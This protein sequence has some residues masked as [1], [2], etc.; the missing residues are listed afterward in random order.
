MPECPFF[1]YLA[2]RSYYPSS[3]PH[4]ETKLTLGSTPVLSAHTLVRTQNR[5]TVQVLVPLCL[6]FCDTISVSLL[7]LVVAI[8]ISRL[9]HRTLSVLLT[10]CGSLTWPF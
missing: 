9:F 2:S 3:Y 10:W 4:K 8:R 5:L 1:H 7:V 6:G